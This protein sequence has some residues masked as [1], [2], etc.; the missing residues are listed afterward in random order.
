MDK[1]YCGGHKECYK[2]DIVYGDASSFQ[3]DI[4]RDEYQLMKTRAG[5]KFDIVIVDE[6]D[7]MLVDEH[8]KSTL[9]STPKPG[10]D[11]LTSLLHIMWSELLKV[12]NNMDEEGSVEIQI[13]AE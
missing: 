8:N 6:V 7:S 13:D 12:Q 10:M 4:L 3:G 5:R 9:L 1:N 11:H 2:C